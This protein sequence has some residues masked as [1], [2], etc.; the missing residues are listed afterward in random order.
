[1]DQQ[2]T[3]DGRDQFIINQ[4]GAVT[5]HTPAPVSRPRAEKRA[6]QTVR[7]EVTSRRAQSLHNAVLIQLGKLPQP[8]QVSHPW[9]SDIKI[10][11]RPAEPIPD[12]TP[13]VNIFEQAQGKLLILGAPGSGKTTTLLDLA[14]ALIERAEQ[15]PDYPIPV[16]FNLS[17]WKDNQQSMQDWLI[18]ELKSKYGVRKDIGT[19]WVE[20]CQLLPLLDGLDEL[21]AI[22]QESCAKAINLLLESDARPPFLVVCS[23]VE[24]YNTYTT[25][26]RLNGAICLRELKFIHR[27]LQKHFAAMPLD[28]EEAIL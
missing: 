22:R 21:E 5:I 28:G 27:L 16:L 8:N 7:N 24:E 19:P 15:Q 10:G 26:L 11:D 25:N 12:D 6:L 17:T 4:P 14:T 9:T 20:N 18:A 3:N 13:I 1:V 23:R 2:N